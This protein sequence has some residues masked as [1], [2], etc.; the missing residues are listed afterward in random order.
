MKPLRTIFLLALSLTCAGAGAQDVPTPTAAH[1]PASGE[2][3]AQQLYGLWRAAFS[4]PGANSVSSTATVLLE[5]HP[6]FP[7]S[8]RGAISR[9]DTKAL[10]SGDLD[11]GQFTLD[12][13]QDGIHIS[14]TWI[15]SLV[16][17]ACGNEIRGTWSDVIHPST[18]D[19][20]LRKLTE[21][22]P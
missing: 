18:R 13:S 1:C 22:T 20:V 3:N 9:G 4:E 10:L 8:V 11:D 19:F 5:R 6:R 21:N 17:Q 14:A 15:G 2:A 12:E 7:E 16:P